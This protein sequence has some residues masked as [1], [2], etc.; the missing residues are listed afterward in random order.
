MP[1][2][3]VEE[4]GRR[5]HF[6]VRL[7]PRAS[8][9]AVAGVREG[10]LHVRV[11]AAPVNGAANRALLELLGKALRLGTTAIRIESGATSARKRLSVP[12][13]AGDALERLRTL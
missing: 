1:D 4:R 8:R 6:A 2:L 10:V 12:C 3:L 5:A 11:T 9:S 7:I 13:D